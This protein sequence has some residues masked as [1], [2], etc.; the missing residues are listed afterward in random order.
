M[1][2]SLRKVERQVIDVG[3]SVCCDFCDKE[4]EGSDESGGLLFGSKAVCPACAP[5]LEADAEMYGE[6]HLIKSRCPE[7]V[8]FHDWVIKLR[9]GNNTVT[10][11]TW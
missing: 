11:T 9:G 5:S 7:G 1:S 8:S 3:N 10:I 2:D 4:Y 6:T